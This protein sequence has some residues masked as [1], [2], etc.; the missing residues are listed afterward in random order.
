MLSWLSRPSTANAEIAKS[1]SDYKEAKTVSGMRAFVV[2]LDTATGYFSNTMGC[3]ATQDVSDIYLADYQ[4]PGRFGSRRLKSDDYDKRAN[5]F[6]QAIRIPDGTIVKVSTKQIEI[7]APATEPKSIKHPLQKDNKS[8][9]TKRDS[10]WSCRA[11]DP[12]LQARN[13]LSFNNHYLLSYSLQTNSKIVSL[14]FLNIKNGKNF[15][16]NMTLD[17]VD[18]FC[19]VP[20]KDRLALAT[21]NELLYCE[22]D[23]DGE[24]I[25]IVR[26][27]QIPKTRGLAN[28]SL[29][30]W[31]L[32]QN[33]KYWTAQSASSC[34][35][36]EMIDSELVLKA[37]LAGQV[38]GW[39]FD[40]LIYLDQDKRLCAL[41][42]NN[43]SNTVLHS[44]SYE[45]VRI[46]PL[47][48]AKDAYILN[49]NSR[50]L[51][52]SFL[53]MEFC[54]IEPT[55]FRCPKMN[56]AERR[57]TSPN[58][59]V[60]GSKSLNEYEYSGTNALVIAEARKYLQDQRLKLASSSRNDKA[61]GDLS[62]LLK[63]LNEG[64]E[65]SIT[66]P[67]IKSLPDSAGFSE[68]LQKFLIIT[69]STPRPDISHA[70][71][72]TLSANRGV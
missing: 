29:Q 37:S 47:A 64:R 58:P 27:I 36:Y 49:C 61:A 10:N 13:Y 65:I 11:D 54:E 67:R 31:C 23:L 70:P 34:I 20:M 69:S 71:S 24:K 41:N 15:T 44:Q 7:T 53:Y 62:G 2:D 33:G 72:I 39:Q 46:I 48:S 16:V 42:P 14:N 4:T 57:A 9:D 43:L 22:V 50:D 21:K 1:A 25:K 32:S 55:L 28:I 3:F 6:Q 40:R 17:S 18:D 30:N 66:D 26:N 38:I 59:K 19:I 8:E 5:E 45:T 12:S 68:I 63:D 52:P 56:T 60:I 51:I 35:L